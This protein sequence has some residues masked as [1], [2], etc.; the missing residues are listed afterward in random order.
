[1]AERGDEEAGAHGCPGNR[2]C[3]CNK[4]VLGQVIDSDAVYIGMIASRRKRDVVYGSLI[5]EGFSADKLN[6]VYS[7]VGLDIKAETPEEIAISIVAEL[8]QVRAINRTAKKK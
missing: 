4:I 8:I 2:V 3:V 6:Q 1:M 5:D 7:P